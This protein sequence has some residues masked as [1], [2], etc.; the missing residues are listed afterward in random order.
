M[1]ICLLVLLTWSPI[2]TA[3]VCDL[4]WDGD[5]IAE[6]FRGRPAY[7]GI[8]LNDRN[9]ATFD[10][11][12]VGQVAAFQEA[13]VRIASAAAINPR[14]IVCS[15][16]APNAFAIPTNDGPVVGVTIGMLKMVDGDRDQA[17][18]ILGHEWAHH[19]LNHMQA[20]QARDAIIGIAGIFLGALV[21]KNTRGRYGT[22][23]GFNLAQ[24]GTQLVSAKFTRDQERDADENGVRYMVAAG[25]NPDGAIRL[26]NSFSRAGMNGVGLF[27]DNHPGWDEREERFKSLIASDPVI[28]RAY[29]RASPEATRV[30]TVQAP[31]VAPAAV[32]SS[33]QTE[34][35]QSQF[36]E[37]IA[38]VRRNDFESAAALLRQSN[39]LGYVPAAT[40]L[41]YLY[42]IGKGVAKDEIEAIRLYRIGVDRGNALAE[43]NL[44]F[45]YQT[46]RGGLSQN[47]EEA[48]RLYKLSAEQNNHQGQANLGAMYAGGRGGLH[49]DPTEAVRLFRLSADQGNAGARAAM[50]F[51]Y[52]TGSGGLPKDDNEARR[53]FQLAADQSNASGQAGLGIFYAT[54]RGGLVKNDAEGIRLVRLSV[55]QGSS[56]GQYA[57]GYAY[58]T[59]KYSLPMDEAEAIRLYR[60]AAAQGHAA[61]KRELEKRGIPIGQLVF[62]AGSPD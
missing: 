50:G 26:A 25:Y 11:I 17:A 52:I 19:N 51:M 59:G 62:G 14:F 55:E 40:T 53:L 3:G 35:G 16:R 46:G 54:G 44:G 21:Q 4:T 43:A 57:L 36:F 42:S 34:P 13:K 15:D 8:R 39:D 22:D 5:K 7:M 28:G 30:A 49:Q 33:A 18:Y 41:G 20:G 12:S 45:M 61:A 32:T 31:P 29:A 58:A 24:I 56:I 10:Q 38:A 2:A 1:R 37:A 6:Q 9:Q 60:L 47:Y 23:F 48:V 27:F